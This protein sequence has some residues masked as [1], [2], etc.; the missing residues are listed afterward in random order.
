MK[1][2]DKP[3][4]PEAE[5]LGET[6]TLLASSPPPS[7]FVNIA[8]PTSEL[9]ESEAQAGPAPTSSEKLMPYVEAEG[10]VL[11]TAEQRKVLDFVREG[12]NCFFTG[13]AGEFKHGKRFSC[14]CQWFT[15][16]AQCHA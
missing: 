7:D 13:A 1:A 10:E 6:E 16:G 15:G 3:T 8:D 5:L 4:S 9:H 12:N 11:L 2:L 14:W